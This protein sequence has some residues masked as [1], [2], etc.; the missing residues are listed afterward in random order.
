MLTVSAGN[1]GGGGLGL[2]RL[3]TV[4]RNRSNRN[5][6]FHRSS[7][8]DKRPRP[9]LPTSPQSRGND[10]IRSDGRSLGVPGSPL[11]DRD[12]PT[13]AS[14]SNGNGD[15]RPISANELA[16]PPPSSGGPPSVMVTT[17]EEVR[18]TFGL[19]NGERLM[20]SSHVPTRKDSQYPRQ[21]MI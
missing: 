2:K 7:S 21:Y 6:M 16:S 14:R 19:R 3:G 12:V 15:Q 5:S 9:P 11:S 17:S 8:P 4:L 13:F 1:H 18:I 20:I 10:S